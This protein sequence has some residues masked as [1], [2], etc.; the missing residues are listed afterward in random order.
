[1]QAITQYAH[2]SVFHQGMFIAYSHVQLSYDDAQ[3]KPV[4]VPDAALLYYY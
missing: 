1:M 2:Y 4:A 3:R